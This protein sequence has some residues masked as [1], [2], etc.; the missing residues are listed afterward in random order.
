MNEFTKYFSDVV[1]FY[2]Y[3]KPQGNFCPRQF[4]K[5]MFVVMLGQQGIEFQLDH[6]VVHDE[7]VLSLKEFCRISN[8]RRF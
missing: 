6:N 4:N 5:A 8:P 7:G 2:V 3:F 1:V